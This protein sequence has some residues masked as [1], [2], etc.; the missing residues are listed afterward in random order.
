[1]PIVQVLPDDLAN[2]IAAGEVV[3]RP[4]SVVKELLENSLDAGATRLRVDVEGGG[5]GLLR[6]SDDG[7]G[8]EEADAKLALARHATSKIK[9]LED[10]LALDTFGF[11]GEA[12][13]S[14]S[15]VSRF[16]LR[17]RRKVDEAGVE[18]RVEGGGAQQI[19]P[20]GMAPGTTVE[21]RDLFFNVPARRKFLKSAGT[22]SA[23]V[24]DT[25]EALALAAPSLTVTLS[26]DGRVVR[27]WLRSTDRGA[28]ARA[29][30]P[31]EDLA[32][33]R[34]ERGE[35]KLL[36]LLGRPERARAS[37]A[38]LKLFVNGRLVRDRVLSRTVLQAYGSVLPAGRYPVGVVF[39][40]VTPDRVDVNVHPQKAEVRFA[41]ARAVSDALFQIISLELGRSF[42]I[43]PVSH[44]YRPGPRPGG[45]GAGAPGAGSG[46][47]G[48]AGSGPGSVSP[49]GTGSFRPGS[50]SGG[51]EASGVRPSS[52][53]PGSSSARDWLRGAQPSQPPGSPEPRSPG[54]GRHFE[55]RIPFGQERDID[56]WGLFDAGSGAAARPPSSP[57][58]P[59]SPSPSTMPSPLALPGR[60]G[61]EPEEAPFDPK[62]PWGLAA[63]GVASEPNDPSPAPSQGSLPPSLAPSQ[64][65]LPPS[66]A[67]SQGS[68]PSIGTVSK[69]L[70]FVAQVRSTYLICE[71]P[72]GLYV[73]DQHAAAERVTFHR[74]R[75][76][77]ASRQVA[78][79]PLLFP[80]VVEVSAAEAA[81]VDE[82]A[83]LVLAAGIDA[84]AVGPTSVAV[85]GVPQIVRRADSER[86]LRD[87]LAQAGRAGAGAYQDAI[88]MALAT[89]A[90]H[91]SVR[92][93]DPMSADEVQALLDA[94]ET[95]DFAGHCP[96]GRPI[97]TA[98]RWD[99]LERKVGRR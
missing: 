54:T 53:G 18:V 3:E 49:G 62:D 13:P 8:L 14:I 68:L 12:L 84:R 51:T 19:R 92:A 38:S 42:G 2:Q 60:P 40:E 63:A 46:N 17:T 80:T 91:G 79:Q 66:L 5:L 36:A 75:Q 89:M 45:F 27:E 7:C 44:P 74:L 65:S 69:A 70:R 64:G 28:R 6:V 99:E 95:V 16:T 15:S 81:F 33:L 29:S 56:P 9:R 88:D 67:P 37:G 97:V 48:P 55:Q 73:L 39:L 20:C 76:Q 35:L 10:L 52:P 98:M 23:H 41:D 25:V 50:S 21:V 26:R 71:G 32:E 24:T 30:F 11:R 59:G 85:H 1:M 58:G 47:V 43:A 4:A 94:L 93:G 34:G 82:N 31:D 61:A 90:C 87:L 86:L 83:E 57:R 22:E 77:F 96:H 78:V 72:D